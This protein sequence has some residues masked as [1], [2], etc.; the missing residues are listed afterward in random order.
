MKSFL[1]FLAGCV[2]GPITYDLYK[3]LL[4]LIPNSKISGA[5]MPVRQAPNTKYWA[6]R[7]KM[8]TGQFIGSNWIFL[9]L[10][11]YLISKYLNKEKWVSV[12]K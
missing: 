6:Y 3:S 7:E 2:A 5:G 11:K 12:S 4:N 10:L 9:L 8:L 1:W